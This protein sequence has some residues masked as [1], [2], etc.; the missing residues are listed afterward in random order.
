MFKKIIIVALTLIPLYAFCKRQ[1]E[2][3]VKLNF[4]GM[5]YTKPGYLFIYEVEEKD[6]NN[7]LLKKD[8]LGLYTTG[9]LSDFAPDT[10]RNIEWAVLTMQNGQYYHKNFLQDQTTGVKLYPSML[11]IHPPRFEGYRILE[12][13][14]M[15]M[16][17]NKKIGGTWHWDLTIGSVWATDPLYPIK[18]I[19]TFKNDY[20][21]KDTTTIN[22]EMG[23]QFC[24]YVT[25]K[26]ISNYGNSYGEYYLNN[27]YG[28]VYFKLETVT[29]ATF[30]FKLLTKINYIL[31]INRSKEIWRR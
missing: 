27:K 2:T 30:E 23:A 5:D 15:P 20:T 3:I 31:Y 18:G 19:D 22:T 11:F 12:F 10:Q 14:P 29:K 25:A 21:M 24:Y 6:F 9:M 16:F 8:T 28:L 17:Y 4:G 7:V 26:S 13:C 1:K